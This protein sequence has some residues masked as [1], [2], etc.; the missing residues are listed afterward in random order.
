ML[1]FD[2]ISRHHAGLRRD[3]V[4]FVDNHLRPRIETMEASRKVDTA[5]ARMIAKHGWIGATISRRWGGM[6]IGHTGKT[7][8]IEELSRA[9]GAAGAIAQASQLGVAMIDHFGSKDQKKKWL[10][11]I[12]AGECLPTIAVTDPDSGGNVL[13]MSGTA[14]RDGAEYVLNGRKVHVGNSHV[15]DL[16]GVVMRTGDGSRG[17]SAFLVEADRD[18]CQV[19]PFSEALGLHGFSFGEIVFDN[20]RVPVSNRLGEEGDGLAAAFSSS[21]LYG[22]PNL[23][24]VS[25]GIHRAIVEETAAYTE[26]RRPYGE[27]LHKLDNIKQRLGAMQSRLV[28]ATLL[29]YQAVCALDKGRECDQDLI[30]AKLVNAELVRDSARDAMD[31]HAAAGLTTSRP[32]QRYLRDAEHPVAPAGTSDVQRLR[33]AEFALGVSKQRWSHRLAN[34]ILGR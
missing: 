28:T 15:G 29:A 34:R 2:D 26:V 27:P 11:R 13:G 12:A 9:S 7:V 14:V 32:L 8:I 22:R 33:L 24:A 5:L 31:V 21:I 6:N 23:A 20:C 25:L 10:P 3:V 18:G 16:H 19:E 17:L 4:A 1:S 30:N